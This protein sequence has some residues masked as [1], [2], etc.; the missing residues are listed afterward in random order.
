MRARAFLFFHTQR[1]DHGPRKTTQTNPPMPSLSLRAA[2]RRN[3]FNRVRDT[4]W[5]GEA[6]RTIFDIAGQGDGIFARA[7]VLGDAVH[8]RIGET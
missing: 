7:K 5:L 4:E 8:H 3:N 1:T 2:P 6:C